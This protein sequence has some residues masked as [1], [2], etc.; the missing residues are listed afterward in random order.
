MPRMPRTRQPGMFYHLTARGVERRSLF[1]LPGDYEY[2]LELVA[3][4][5]PRMGIG[6]MS[7]C[8]M[9]NHPHMLVEDARCELSDFI[10]R[11]H[12]SYAQKFN[13]R[14]TRVGHLFQGRFHAKPVES[15]RYLTEVLRY[16]HWN[17]VSAKLCSRPG[18]Y[19]WSSAAAY[20]S[21]KLPDWMRAGFLSPL[22][23]LPI[24]QEGYADPGI[25]ADTWGHALGVP[26]YEDAESAES[27]LEEVAR[28]TGTRSICRTGKGRRNAKIRMLAAAALRARTS[29]SM[30]EI[31]LSLGMGSAAAVSYACTQAKAQD[32]PEFRRVLTALVSERNLTNGV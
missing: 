29:L 16:I 1:L 9:P 21:G 23:G 20:E 5:A 13:W 15:E 30:R 19:R 11:V 28:L 14:E 6:V 17:P 22:L 27:V 8:L 2:Y 18:D 4:F 24:G 25:H 31:A 7:Y 26:W 3:E 32:D 10:Q 12:G